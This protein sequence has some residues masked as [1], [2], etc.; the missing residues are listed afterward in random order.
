MEKNFHYHV[1]Y[2][3]AVLAGFSTDDALVIARAAQYV[4]DC[5]G[6]TIQ[7]SATIAWANMLDTISCGN[8]EILDLLDIWPVFH[9][10][11]GDFSDVS[12]D[13]DPQLLADSR[14]HISLAPTL[15]CRPESEMTKAI[16]HGAKSCYQMESED[17]TKRLQ[18][19]G[20]VMHVLADT[21]AHQNFAGIPL[22]LVNE[23]TH[24]R[25]GMSGR[26]LRM[27]PHVYSP[28]GFS[29]SSF[30]YLGHGR[31]GYLPDR[32][33]ETFVYIAAWQNPAGDR[34]IS[35]YNPLEFYCAFLQMEEAMKFIL[36][37]SPGDFPNRIDRPPLLSDK[38]DGKW[39]EVAPFLK[40]FED[41]GT[42]AGIPDHWYKAVG[43]HIRP[44]QRAR[45]Y[46]P[47]NP[48]TESA[49]YRSFLAAAYDHRDLVTGSCEPLR[50]Y[51]SL[52][53]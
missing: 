51:Q 41:A 48:E 37:N 22:S 20:I 8:Q 18:R 53:S 21:Y 11:P 52:F 36:D 23:V 7:G 30:G 19:I 28:A 12:E 3:A 25:L 1:T 29:R 2:T 43:E 34:F 44:V 45:D 15:I 6:K 31:M 5:N 27:R 33:G 16:V 4:D 39:R 46:A 40:A 14:P 10:L 26:N 24:V 47:Y 49:L 50:D 9:F 32:P 42:D 17:R 13:V 38:E 35:R